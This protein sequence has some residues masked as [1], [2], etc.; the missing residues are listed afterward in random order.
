MVKPRQ[1][2][3]RNVSSRKLFTGK[4]MMVPCPQHVARKI[5]RKDPHGGWS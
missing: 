4:S 1:Y 5:R 3:K 2:K